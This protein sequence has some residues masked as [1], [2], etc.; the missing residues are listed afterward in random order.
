[1]AA[2]GPTGSSVAIPER[3][4]ADANDAIVLRI[5]TEQWPLSRFRWLAQAEDLA[6]MAGA[7]GLRTQIAPI[8]ERR[9]LARQGEAA[10][11]GRDPLIEQRL[12]AARDG[13]LA[14]AEKERLHRIAPIDAAAVHAAFVAQPDALDELQLSHILVRVGAGASPQADRRTDAQAAARIESIRADLA[15]GADFATL[16]RTHSEDAASAGEGGVL[17][18]IHREDLKPS[19]APAIRALRRG[20]VSAS[21]RGDDGYHL[22]RLDEVK[23]A[24][25]ES[26]GR[27]LEYNLRE[28]WVQQQLEALLAA[29][30]VTFD[31]SIWLAARDRLATG[32]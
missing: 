6:E 31:P 4:A 22:I 15:A 13:I 21:I 25:L 23:P 14:D 9:L 5:G 11:V 3:P 29:N 32:R 16:A 20:Q 17:P 12:A 30:P 7:D 18:E 1:M 10:G 8:A 19:V 24:T 28:K 26:K 27:L 2:T